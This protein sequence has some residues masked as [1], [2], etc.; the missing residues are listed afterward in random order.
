M[1]KRGKIRGLCAV[2]GEKGSQ[3]Q[4]NRHSLTEGGAVS[5]DGGVGRYHVLKEILKG[6][7]INKA[8]GNN[9]NR[10]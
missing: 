7:T 6:A 3:Q 5:N 10:Q 2:K 1:Q 8:K 4:S 9:V